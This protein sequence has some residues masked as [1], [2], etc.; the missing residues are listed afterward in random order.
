MKFQEYLER[1]K[2][3][4]FKKGDRLLFLEE[5]DFLSWWI[6]RAEKVACPLFCPFFARN[7]MY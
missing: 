4:F 6:V 1:T 3:I 5:I 2:H 7:L